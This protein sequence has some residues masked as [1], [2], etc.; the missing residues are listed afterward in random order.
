MYYYSMEKTQNDNSI[1]LYNKTVVVYKDN[2]PYCLG[3]IT[4][5]KKNCVTVKL[6]F[7]PTKFSF[8][9]FSRAH[10]NREHKLCL[11]FLKEA[12]FYFDI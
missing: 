3:D 1:G 10:I 12:P 9:R 7:G 11:Y 8:E 5:S 6:S 4:E 2:K